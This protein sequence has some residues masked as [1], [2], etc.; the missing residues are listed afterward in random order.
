V[1]PGLGQH[2]NGHHRRAIAY[3]AAILLAGTASV[4][5][6]LSHHQ[7]LD[8]YE[9]IRAQIER[10][11]PQHVELTAEMKALAD[12]QANAYDEAQSARKL[13]MA[14]QIVVGF[15]WAVNA[16]DGLR[17]PRRPLEAG[18]TINARPSRRF[19]TV[20]TVSVPF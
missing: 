17:E 13:A 8:D 10:E 18:V 7:K 11:A 19:G 9:A 5:A 1:L 16:L 14:S 20:A 6:S 2:L 3:E 15:L 4:V 12:Q